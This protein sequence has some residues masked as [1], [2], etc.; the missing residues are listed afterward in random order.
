MGVPARLPGLRSLVHG[1][2]SVR[3]D[4]SRNRWARFVAAWVLV[5]ALGLDATARA[6]IGIVESLTA[7]LDVRAGDTVTRT[8]TVFN[9]GDTPRRVRVALFDRAPGAQRTFVD[10]KTLPSS[11]AALIRPE[12]DEFVVA[13]GE[14]RPFT[15]SV[16]V[17][18]G[19]RESKTLWSILMFE[20]A[21][22]LQDARP[23]QGIGIR[24]QT[25]F[26]YSV[27]IHVNDPKV[28]RVTIGG[29]SPGVSD[30]PDPRELLVDTTLT[31]EGE[32]VT[33]VTAQAQAF[34]RETGEQIT[35]TPP[36]RL[37]LYPGYPR[38]VRFDLS[39]L[40]PGAYEILLLAETTD[41]DLYA[42][43]FDLDVGRERGD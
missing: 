8:V 16:T 41:D 15:F 13:A 1:F 23:T 27:I 6:S 40:D 24:T 17:P 37:R 42:A 7:T 33:F 11:A 20:P 36:A 5:A 18:E 4:R 35:A 30:D 25:R 39:A 14:N 34:D 29:V 21:Q 12:V 22:N 43:R 9:N 32:R 19:M 31:V 3:T 10:A 28:K 26:A 38:D 2:D